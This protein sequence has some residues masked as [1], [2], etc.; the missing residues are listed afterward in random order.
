MLQRLYQNILKHAESPKAFWWYVGIAF[1]ESSFF[2]LPPDLMMIPMGVAKRDLVWRL[3]FW[4]TVSSVI[5][6]LLGYAIGAW[7]V[8]TAGQWII[9]MYG[10]EESAKSFHDHYAKWGFWIIMLKGLTPIP[11]KLVTIASG[12][13]HYPILPFVVASIIAR[14]FRFYLLATLLWFF[15]PKAKDL[16]DRYLGWCLTGGLFIIVIG[17][18]IL[19][20]AF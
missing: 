2:L 11:Y 5:G 17:F 1:A 15:G 20:Y 9:H 6:G 13:A 3:A 4:G 12:I 8:D 18:I 19:K 10:L 14:G 7:F 16:L